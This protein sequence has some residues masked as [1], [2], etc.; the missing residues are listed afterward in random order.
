MVAI[1]DPDASTPESPTGGSVRHFLGG[2]FVLKD[3]GTTLVNNT[4][5]ITEYQKPDP[6]KC[7]KPHRSVDSIFPNCPSQSFPLFLKQMRLFVVQAA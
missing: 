1:V 6:E 2:D 4:P 5:A 7:S 3:D